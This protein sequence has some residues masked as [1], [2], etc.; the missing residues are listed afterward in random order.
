MT[1]GKQNFVQ[2]TNRTDIFAN[3]FF[4]IFLN[5][6][7]LPILLSTEQWMKNLNKNNNLIAKTGEKCAAN[8]L[9]TI[10]S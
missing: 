9:H 1:Q 4:N 7:S 3:A 2:K 8:K 6:Y 5:H 10:E